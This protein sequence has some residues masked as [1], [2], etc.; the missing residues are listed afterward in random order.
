ML[1]FNYLAWIAWPQDLFL[2][3]FVI[4]TSLAAIKFSVSKE[5]RPTDWDRLLG[6]TSSEIRYNNFIRRFS[7]TLT[8]IH[9]RKLRFTLTLSFRWDL[10]VEKFNSC[11]PGSLRVWTSPLLM[12]LE[13]SLPRHALA[14]PL[15]PNLWQRQISWGLKRWCGEP[16]LAEWVLLEGFVLRCHL[17]TGGVCN[18]P[19]LR[20][21]CFIH[22]NFQVAKG[23]GTV[24]AALREVAAHLVLIELRLLERIHSKEGLSWLL[25][26]SSLLLLIASI[27]W[28]RMEVNICQFKL[29]QD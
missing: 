26:C 29:A 12:F 6:L 7:N 4:Q 19:L 28:S 1:T 5:D 11:I 24:K 22:N 15:R 18:L 2:N 9:A 23:L 14:L 27:W 13:D 21:C 16:I 8:I 17:K 10:S 3:V 25:G 20:R